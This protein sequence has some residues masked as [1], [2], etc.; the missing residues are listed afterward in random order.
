MP[1]AHIKK[2]TDQLPNPPIN[3]GNKILPEET[4]RHNEAGVCE[5]RWSRPKTSVNKP[6]SAKKKREAILNRIYTHFYMR[7]CMSFQN[8]SMFSVYFK[9]AFTCEFSF[10]NERGIEATQ[11]NSTLP[12]DTGIRSQE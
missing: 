5:T 4:L 12:T 10:L 9:Y 2:D 8:K 1:G 3:T 11:L 6:I 7:P